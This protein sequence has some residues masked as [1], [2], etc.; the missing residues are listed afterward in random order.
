MMSSQI[1]T[2]ARGGGGGSGFQLISAL[3]IY[4]FFFSGRKGLEGHPGMAILG[5]T[6]GKS[7]SQTG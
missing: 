6:Q 7:K 5:A 1:P 3:L 4:K 2:L